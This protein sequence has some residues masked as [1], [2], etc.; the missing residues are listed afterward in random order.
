MI[1]EIVFLCGRIFMSAIMI[2]KLAIAAFMLGAVGILVA[3]THPASLL[4]GK[5]LNTDGNNGILSARVGL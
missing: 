2:R 5:P 3:A 1:F 4:R